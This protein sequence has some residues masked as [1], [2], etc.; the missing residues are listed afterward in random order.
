[1]KKLISLLLILLIFITGC[2][3]KI[4]DTPEVFTQKEAIRILDLFIEKETGYKIC[5]FVGE[6]TV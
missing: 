3:Q 2:S 6:E 5:G 4:K 1:M